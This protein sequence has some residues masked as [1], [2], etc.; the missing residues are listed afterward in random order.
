MSRVRLWSA[1]SRAC[2]VGGRVRDIGKAIEDYVTPFGYAMVRDFVGHG[3]GT[4]MHE[5]PQI[6]N[7][8]ARDATVRLKAGLVIAIEPMVNIGTHEVKTLSDGWTAVTAD[9]KRSAH[10]EHSVAITDSGPVVLSR[11]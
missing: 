2:V 10:F 5:E 1:A 8:Y 6:P 3:I 7:Y 11:P 9:R 4:R